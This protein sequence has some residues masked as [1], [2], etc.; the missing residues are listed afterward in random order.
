MADDTFTDEELLRIYQSPDADLSLLSQTELARLDTLTQ[1]DERPAPSTFVDEPTTFMGGFMKSLGDTAGRTASGVVRGV[2]S[3]LNPVN[4]VMGPLALGSDL[5]M[6][7]GANTIAG[8]KRIASGDPDAGGEAIGA[9]AMGGI[10][11]PR[12]VPKV[13]NALVRSGTAIKAGGAAMR[14][15]EIPLGGIGY[16]MGGPKG[17]ALA[18]ATPSALRG[19]GHFIKR[20][21]EAL[22]GKMPASGPHPTVVR[23]EQIVK[24]DRLAGA[25]PSRPPRLS[26]PDSLESELAGVL[27]NIRQA[28]TVNAPALASGGSVAERAARTASARRHMQPNRQGAY[29]STVPERPSGDALHGSTLTEL[30]NPNPEALPRPVAAH[31][32]T[33]APAATPPRGVFR[34][35]MTPG[36]VRKELPTWATGAPVSGPDSPMW[37]AGSEMG[38]GAR[39]V[40][41]GLDEGL[42]QQY[43]QARATYPQV[44]ADAWRRVFGDDVAA[45]EARYRQQGGEP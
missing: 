24:N 9:L 43:A 26:R 25:T 7:G 44:S 38:G 32:Q 42:Y 16:L 40:A 18:A 35:P 12:L 4:L 13:P 15:S 36:Q 34:G 22:G 11:L 27:D 29:K 45:L 2:R 30:A 31:A 1:A 39:S 5:L 21:G 14:S 10:G 17:A 3:S 23:L 37:G 33:P 41:R 20:G 28:D 6:N 8:I 19:A